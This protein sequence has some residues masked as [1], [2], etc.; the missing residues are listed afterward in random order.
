MTSTQVLSQRILQT[1][2]QKLCKL[3]RLRIQRKTANIYPGV[4]HCISLASLPS[5]LFNS[6]MTIGTCMIY[7][8]IA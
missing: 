8:F 5:S 2:I 1:Q 3:T 7:S 4:S 6:I